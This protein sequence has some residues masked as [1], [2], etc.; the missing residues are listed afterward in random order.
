MLKNLL[1]K[2]AFIIVFALFFVTGCHTAPAASPALQA[3][4]PPK[5]SAAAQATAAPAPSPTPQAAA[6]EL[7]SLFTPD[8]GQVVPSGTPMPEPSPEPSAK[9]GVWVPDSYFGVNG[10]HY[11]VDARGIGYIFKNSREKY[12]STGAPVANPDASQVSQA[13][14]VSVK[15]G[16]YAYFFDTKQPVMYDDSVYGY[17][18][19]RRDSAGA[20]V[21]L[22]IDGYEII[23]GRQCIYVLNNW[24]VGDLAHWDVWMVSPDGGSKAYI[25]DDIALYAPPQGNYLYFSGNDY[26]IYRTGFSFSKVEKLSLET[27]DTA[28]IDELVEPNAIGFEFSKT[29]GGWLYFNLS[30]FNNNDGRSYNGGYKMKLAGGKAV[31]T[32]QGV[33]DTAAVTGDDDDN[34]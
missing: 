1:M 4:A 17:P 5:A 28:K 20:V 26:C 6:T 33:Y 13:E 24:S 9:P 10:G 7:S 12:F 29:E 30:A 14:K 16:G 25:G 21:N 15:L 8:A 11:D 19:C 18:V 31:N 23:P 27:P 22:G 2:S 3:S 34:E 32:D